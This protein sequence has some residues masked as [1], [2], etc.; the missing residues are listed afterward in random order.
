MASA[1]RDSGA[2]EKDRGQTY[3]KLLRGG[4][5]KKTE[6]ESGAGLD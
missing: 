3:I 6:R 5:E 1:I 4:Q 2:V